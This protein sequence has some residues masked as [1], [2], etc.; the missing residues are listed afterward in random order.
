MDPYRPNPPPPKFLATTFDNDDN[1]DQNQ[2]SIKAPKRKRLAKVLLFLLSPHSTHPRSRLVMP[3]TR[4]NVA[5]MVQSSSSTNPLL[6]ALDRDDDKAQNSAQNC[7]PRKRFRDN[8]GNAVPTE[9]ISSPSIPIPIVESTLL[10]GPP[11]DR[12]A[13][14]ELDHDLTRELTNL[15][16]THC[17]PARIIIHKPTFTA[18]LA[19]NRVPI[20]LLHAVCALA[21]PLSKQPRLRTTPSRFAGQR[22]AQEAQSLMFDG[23]GRLVCERNLMSAQALCLLQFHDLK[24][25]DQNAFW[26]SRYH[27]VAMQLVESLN[28]YQHDYPTL[29]P[30]PS[31]EFIQASIEREAV[32]RMFWIIHLLDNLA[33]IYFRKPLEGLQEPGRRLRLPVDETTF[34]LGVHSTLPEYLYLPAVRMQ[35]SSEFGHLIRVVSIYAKVESALNELADPE[36]SSNAAGA[37]LDAEHL[38]DSWANTLPEHLR[39]SEQSLQVQQSMFETSSNAGA[40]CWCG[41]HV[42]HASSILALNFA[43]Q[44]SQKGPKSEPTW[45]LR[46]LDLILEMLG[47]RAKNSILM[48]AAIW[49]RDFINRIHFLDSPRSLQALIKYCQRDDAQIRNWCAVYED[50][51]GTRMRE[52]VMDRLPG[53]PS[54]PMQHNYTPSHLQQGSS[55]AASAPD[56]REESANI[57]VTDFFAPARLFIQPQIGELVTDVA[58]LAASLALDN[59]SLI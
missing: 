56:R 24:T 39:F 37:L 48:A 50:A 57:R 30:V 7:I 15:F 45:A 18:N 5:A 8:R 13:P 20:Y 42:F 4:A 17:H 44:Q 12:P 26:D 19:H 53:Y 23:A 41:M 34:E 55:P 51:W 14:L 32:R 22:F 43:R 27:D 3:A 46:M 6:L 31:A 49:V 11:I 28:V 21:A 58:R 16:F 10:S 59:L 35:Y 54:P 33:F 52:L 40:W 2:N 36:S 9:D 29:T 1:D 38:M 25:K 47:D